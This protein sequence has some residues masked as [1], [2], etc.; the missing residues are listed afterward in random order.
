MVKRILALVLIYVFAVLG[1][2]ILGSV[3][4]SRTYSQDNKLKESVG[5]LWGTRQVQTAPSVSYQ[6]VTVKK[7]TRTEDKKNIVETKEITTVY[8]VNLDSSAIKAGFN[9]DYRKKGL[10]WYSTYKVRVNAVYGV[11]NPYKE[12]KDI[13]F[14]YGF[15][16]S[17]GVYDDF[18]ISVDGVKQTD[19][20][21]E[22]GYIVLVKSF[23]P[24]V[25]HLIEI[26]YIS[27]GLDSWGYAFGGEVMN[28][29]DF[30]LVM[31]T[32]FDGIDFPEK[33]MS[34]STKKKIKGGWELEWKYKNLLSGIN[35][36]LV[37]P[38]KLNPGPFASEVSF[39][40]PV[41]LFFFFFLMFIITT[42]KGIKIHPLNYFFLAAAFFAFHLLL[43]YLAD[44]VDIYMAFA[45]ASVVSI[46]LVISYMRLVVGTKFALVEVGLSQFVYLVVFSSAF[47]LQGYTGLTITILAVVTLY[48]I[49]QI[50]AK[51]D[52][53]K[54]FE[55]VKPV[56][57]QKNKK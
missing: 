23:E 27:Q 45:I 31:T 42:I 6:I 49:M 18:S 43:A 4:Y 15:P 33:A 38:Q 35:I 5:G 16:S 39:F 56:L 29:K 20:K 22:A 19:I 53:E 51:V 55:M 1:W 9:L 40:A 37:M 46:F 57:K 54:Q 25:K 48:V 10:L 14:T 30:S 44:V 41:S 50:T 17:E 13:S 26:N 7:I 2:V 28:V 8:P 34:P 52:W 24:G 32:D 12:K 21:P 3:T 47:F 36:G 11:I